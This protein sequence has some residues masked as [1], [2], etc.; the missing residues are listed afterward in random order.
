MDKQKKALVV[1][2]NYGFWG[3]ELQAVWDALKTAG[4][5]V[6][7]ATP[8][9]KRPLPFLISVDPD[10]VDPIQK[11]HVNPPAV[12]A[13]VKELV[14]GDDWSRPL[15]LR[16][17]TMRDYDCLVLAG[18]PGTDLDMTNNPDVH[19]LVLEGLIWGKLIT[20][21]CFS[22][23]A[24]AFTRDPANG[25]RSVLRG[26]RVT[27]HP[28]SW[29][30]QADLTYDLYGAGKSDPGTNVVT[31]GFLLPVQD[32]VT[33][34]VGPEGSVVSDPATSRERPS[35]VF[36]PPFIT[37]CSV[38]S[39]IAFGRKVVEVLANWPVAAG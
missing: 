6:R 33:D 34:A 1:A 21:I 36:D 25:Y 14:A 23:A 38:E 26:R 12:C 5:D 22:V 16:D 35:V 31:P 17:T 10:F 3:E 20:A 13:R 4:N 9:G 39:S 2:S 32:L 8:R 27:A 30:F 7:L 11:Y 37:A 19:R 28:R 29:D 18:G 24:L 15:A